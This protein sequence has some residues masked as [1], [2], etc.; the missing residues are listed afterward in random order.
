MGDGEVFPLDLDRGRIVGRSAEF[1]D[2]RFRKPG[3]GFGQKHLILRAFRAGNARHDSGEIELDRVGEDR[4]CHVGAPI[5][6]RL[7][8]GFDKRNAI[9]ITASIGEIFD[10]VLIDWEE[11]AGRAKF[12]RHV[13]QGRLV[14]QRQV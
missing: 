1:L 2:H 13:G 3:I 9:S 14:F 6:L 12:W 4:V 11:G 8:I 10:R 7:G 5:A